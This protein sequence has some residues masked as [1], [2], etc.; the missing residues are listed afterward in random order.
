MKKILLSFMFAALAGMAVMAAEP[1]KQSGAVVQQAEPDY[2]WDILAFAFTPDYPA[3]SALATV[4]GVKV[5]LPMSGGSAPV[6]GV[7]ASVLY[8]G[9]DEVTGVQASLICTDAKEVTGLQFSLVNFSVK[10]AGIQLGI[11]NFADDETVQI[12]LLNFI[13][14][15]K[16]FCLPIFNC[17]F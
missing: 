6:Y 4:G 1:A 10:V 14:N 7:E 16:V 11:V 8:A 3:A 12:G 9:S 17:K 15:G 13:E 5:G 2:G